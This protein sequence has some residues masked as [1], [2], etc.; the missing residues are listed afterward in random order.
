MIIWIP[1]DYLKPF[2]TTDIKNDLM[3]ANQRADQFKGVRKSDSCLWHLI[4][5]H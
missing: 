3:K 4:L 2:M 1:Y 5:Y